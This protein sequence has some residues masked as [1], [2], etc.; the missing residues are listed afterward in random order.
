MSAGIHSIGPSWAR[1]GGYRSIA[2]SVSIASKW[3]DAVAMKSVKVK[4]QQWRFSLEE[5]P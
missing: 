1:I 4:Q 2:T 5:L 3:P